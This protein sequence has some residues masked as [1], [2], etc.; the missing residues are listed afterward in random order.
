MSALVV[1][2]WIAVAVAAASAVWILVDIYARG[3]RQRM[4]IMEAVWPI[5][6]LYF[7]PVAVW[8]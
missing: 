8:G 2:S 4:G 1:V 5:S 7:G 3:H 6:A